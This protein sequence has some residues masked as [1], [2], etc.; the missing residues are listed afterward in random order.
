[1]I[2]LQNF[3]LNVAQFYLP[4]IF[5]TKLLIYVTISL[6]FSLNYFT[7]LL[8]SKAIKTAGNQIAGLRKTTAMTLRLF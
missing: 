4:A 5:V 6:Q 3:G 1:M 7:K 2:V 8:C